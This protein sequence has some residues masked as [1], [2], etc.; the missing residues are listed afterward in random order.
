M[1]SA[2]VGA[3]VGWRGLFAIG[4]LAAAFAFVIPLW[5]PESPRWLFGQGR[6]EDARRSLAWALNVDPR[7]IQLPASLPEP[8]R[9]SWFELFKYP[10]SIIAAMLTG[11]R[12]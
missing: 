3:I 9:A 2:S 7:E 8:E 12:A 4:L 11:L 6:Y 1:L 10:R 5:V